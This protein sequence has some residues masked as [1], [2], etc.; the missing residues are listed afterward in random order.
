MLSFEKQASEWAF[1]FVARYAEAIR[2]IWPDRRLATL[3]YQHYQ[4]PPE[5]MRIP[6]NVDVTYVT[7]VVHYA[8][9][10]D[11]FNQELEKVH[12]W[13]KLLN[14][15]TERFGNRAFRNLAEYRRPGHIYLQ[16]PIYVP[17]YF[18]TL[19]VGNKGRN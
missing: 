14:N 12:A 3:A 7:K 15:K 6:D 10:P 13:S 4:A 19:A 8:S 9:D 11:L 16:G 18:Q 2:A 1:C 17:Q 5:G